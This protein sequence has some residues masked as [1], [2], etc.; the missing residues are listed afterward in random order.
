MKRLSGFFFDVMVVAGIAAIRIDL[1]ANYWW[2]VIILGVVGLVST[3]A[4]NAYVAKTLFKDYQDEQFLMMYG[5]LTG[6][7]S[8]GMVLLKEID[9]ELKTPASENLVYQNFP[10][11]VL[12]FPIMLLANIAPT[13]PVLVLIILS[14]MFIVLNVFLFRSKLF[15]KKSKK[16]EPAPVQE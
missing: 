15:K 12:G 13:Q 10:A 14:A 9:G 6:T 3:Y 4:Y 11:I 8:T 16:V 7:A 1:L 2:I 5:M